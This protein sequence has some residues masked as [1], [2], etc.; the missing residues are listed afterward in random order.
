MGLRILCVTPWFPNYPTDGRYNFI[1]HS[2]RALASAG[3]QM[4]VLVTRPWV[5]KLFAMIK[6]NW[7]HGRLRREQFDLAANIRVINYFHI[8][9]HIL[10][11]FS[12]SLYKY[13][14]AASIRNLINEHNIDIV[15]A[16]TERAGYGAV[17]MARRCNVPTVV[18]VHGINT[19]PRLLD[20]AAKRERL[21]NTLNGAAR[22]V[23]VGEPLRAYF[24]PLAGRDDNF[25]VVPN[26]FVL[27]GGEQVANSGPRDEALRFIS[28]SNLQE[29][30]GIDLNLQALARLRAAGFE[31]WLY[32]I[33]G[34][35]ME[36]ARL[37]KMT[38]RLG[39]RDQVRFYGRLPHD[40]ALQ[41]LAAADVFVLPSYREAFGVAYLEAMA[42]GLLA[43]GVADQGPAAFII[44]RQTGLL[45]K[46]NDVES[47]YKAMRSTFEN[48]AEMQRIA[49]AGKRLVRSEYTWTRH[50]DKL[51]SVYRE[52]LCGQ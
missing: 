26:G 24:A 5:P 46:P 11:E 15:H 4:T 9:R 47:L 6:P 33:I 14:T 10:S 2:V 49:L 13:G 23:L 50:A 19:A 41:L 38:N 17:A 52:A 21:R 34:G 3:N 35:G 29:G 22:V 30:K 20:S 16:H 44:H 28:V 1:F 32:S 18:T 7:P 25:R 43:I 12:D 51:V 42:S 45:V 40:R 37:E 36:Q 39:L 8:P 31:N 48:R 27:H